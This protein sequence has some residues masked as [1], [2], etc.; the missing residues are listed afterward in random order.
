VRSRSIASYKCVAPV[1]G[2]NIVRRELG[3]P[4]AHICAAD[5]RPYFAN[6]GEAG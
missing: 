1:E 5:P 3:F 6:F 2:T 4:E